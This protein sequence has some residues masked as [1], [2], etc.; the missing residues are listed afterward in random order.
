M[1]DELISFETAKLAKEKEFKEDCNYFFSSSYSK[2]K[3]IYTESEIMNK[4]LADDEYAAPTQS[5]L[6]RWL[7]ENHNINLFVFKTKCINSLKDCWCCEDNYMGISSI[8][9]EST[10][11]Y[12][13]ALEIGLVKG[14][15]LI[16]TLK[17]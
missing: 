10:H 4:Y 5:L 3:Y 17:C 11:T 1:K 7:R 15:S 14:L 8:S 16:K 12:E 6:Q 13:E 9:T 2:I